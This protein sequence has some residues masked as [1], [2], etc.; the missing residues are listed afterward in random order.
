LGETIFKKTGRHKGEQMEK[1]GKQ[2]KVTR[3]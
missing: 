1:K 2:S 3:K